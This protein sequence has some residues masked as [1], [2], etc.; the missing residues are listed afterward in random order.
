L[1]IERRD[2]EGAALHVLTV[3]DNV[4]MKFAATTSMAMLPE[5]Q[6][7]IEE[8]GRN[9]RR[10]SGRHGLCLF[11]CT[12]D[13]MDTTTSYLGLRLAHP[14]VAGAS[15]LSAH[16]DTVKRLED[17]GAAAIVLH[18]L[19]E[20]QIT[21]AESGRIRRMDPLDNQFGATLASFPKPGDYPFSPD[22]HVEHV[23]RV[24]QAVKIPV[25]ASLNGT[26]AEAWLKYALL[27][28]QAGADAIEVNFYEVVTDLAVPGLA[29]E[30]RIRNIALEL[31]QALRIPVA[32]KLSPFFTAFGNVARRLDETGIDGLVIF[33]R[34][35]QPDIDIKTVSAAPRLELS[36]SAE[37]LLRLRWLAILNGRIRAS[38]ALTGGVETTS[39]GIKAVLAGA[40]AVQMVSALLRHGPGF[41]KS[42]REGL[43]QWMEWHQ[44]ESIDQIRGRV[45]LAHASDPSAFERAN[46]I[47]MLHSWGT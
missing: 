3:V 37:L 1:R 2:R 16:L 23:R 11:P 14:F 29:V 19:F 8:V 43:E 13:H 7:L 28:Q 45:S 9:R 39:D 22:D 15:P 33:N 26:T 36:R 27:F 46:Y 10:T 32:I 12:G 17:G 5:L 25:I 42:M 24:K 47:H 38:L 41:L 18:S 44:I 34:F 20:E 31:K 30:T 6:T 21:L 35:Y 4:M 40:H